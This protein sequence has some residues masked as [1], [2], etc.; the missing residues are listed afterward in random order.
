M[1]YN[2]KED[3][4]EENDLSKEMPEKIAQLDKLLRDYVQSVDGGEVEDV[5][6]AALDTFDGFEKSHRKAYE[7]KRSK[8]IKSNP[9]DLDAQ[10]VKLREDLDKK[11]LAIKVKREMIK[12]QRNYGDW[13]SGAAVSTMKRIGIKK[14]GEITDPEKAEAFLNQ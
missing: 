9:T 6:Q 2:V 3:Y 12:D 7:T 5:Y 14:S 1:L 4:R 8:L 13:H 11:L 10:L